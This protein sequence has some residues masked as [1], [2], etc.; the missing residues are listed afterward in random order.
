M[1]ALPAVDPVAVIAAAIV[2]LVIGMVWYSPLGFEKK[3]LALMG[4]MKSEIKGQGKAV[5][6]WF[7]VALVMAYVLGV[8]VTIMGS[9]TWVDGAVTGFLAWLGFMATLLATETLFER[10]KRGLAAI[11]GGYFLVAMVVT[12]AILAA[13]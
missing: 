4:L 12:G 3:W 5:A 1:V 11:L 6:G 8:F 2:N 7:V 10:K 9:V 13:L